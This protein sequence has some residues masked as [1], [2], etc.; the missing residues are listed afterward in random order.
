MLQANGCG[1]KSIAYNKPA[2][3]TR[4]FVQWWLKV[5]KRFEILTDT[6][7]IDGVTFDFK[8]TSVCCF[9]SGYT[10]YQMDNS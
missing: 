7:A 8:G 10:D 5:L 3:L 4:E 1:C 6:H 9:V 2:N